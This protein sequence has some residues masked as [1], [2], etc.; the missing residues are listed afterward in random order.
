[1]SDHLPQWLVRPLVKQAPG[2]RIKGK[3]AAKYLVESG[4]IG[5]VESLIQQSDDA[6]SALNTQIDDL[7]A[8]GTGK[9]VT[10][11][12]DQ[13]VKQLVEKINSAGGAIDDAQLLGTIDNLAPQARGLLGKK[14]LTLKEA[15]Q[16]R[17]LLD[18]TLGDRAFFAQ[19]LTNNKEILMSFTNA[20]R[21]SVKSS[22]DALRPLYTEYSKNITIKNALMA[23]ATAGGGANSVG[24]SDLITG[25]VA[26]TA[27][28]NPIVGFLAAGGRRALES[29]PVKT[30][31]AQVFKNADKAI[32]VLEAMAPESRAIVLE[33]ISELLDTTPQ[34]KPR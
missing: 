9:G 11:S 14:T 16:L 6:M 7:I 33:L 26:F 3:D 30:A 2:A 17:K 31:L 4:N 18:S 1:M 21:E 28:G 34:E 24:L 12:R 22:D 5:T 29:A 15:N 32:P 19:Q 20:L 13:I 27:S 10:I 8:Q 25:G 23:R